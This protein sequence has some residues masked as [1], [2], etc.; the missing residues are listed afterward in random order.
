MRR[1]HSSPTMSTAADLPAFGSICHWSPLWMLRTLHPWV[2]MPILHVPCIWQRPLSGAVKAAH[3]ALGSLSSARRVSAHCVPDIPAAH[4]KENSQTRLAALSGT[5][6]AL[7]YIVVL[8]Y[9]ARGGRN[10]MACM[11][12]GAGDALSRL[13]ENR[14]AAFNS[15]F[16]D[17]F[18][19]F[20]RGTP[21][22][23]HWC[24]LRLPYRTSV[25]LSSCCGKGKRCLSRFPKS[26]LLHAWLCPILYLAVYLPFSIEKQDNLHGGCFF[27]GLRLCKICEALS[28]CMADMLG[29]FA[30]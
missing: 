23:S 26:A 18:G 25:V 27:S 10:E 6:G 16:N 5:L 15:R 3:S 4:A 14:E 11:P 21:E 9:S 17:K 19:A 2:C 12:S 29:L 7:L 28:G 8:M 20:L 30:V 13:L 1:W 22:G 24:T